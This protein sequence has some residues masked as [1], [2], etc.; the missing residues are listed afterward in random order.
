MKRRR[1]IGPAELVVERHRVIG[2]AHGE[3][4]EHRHVDELSARRTAPAGGERPDGGEEPGQPLPDLAADMDR[5]PIGQPAGKT[6][7]RPRP[8]LEGELGGRVVAPRTLEP[9][10]RDRRDD[11]VRMASR[12]SRRVRAMP[13]PPTR[14]P[15]DQTT[16]SADA[17]SWCSGCDDRRASQSSTTDT[18]L[19]RS[20]EIEERAIVIGRDLGARGGPSA[21]RIALG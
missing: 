9:K 19:R 12:G 6:H 20:Q 3:G 10:W 7:H 5:R 14:E 17:R 2:E 8:R 4:L 18:A 11:Q 16:A 15:R 1:R 13:A 21:Q